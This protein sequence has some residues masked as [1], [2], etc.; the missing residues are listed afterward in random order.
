MPRLR[1]CSVPSKSI[2]GAA[3]VSQLL[4]SAAALFWY[5]DVKVPAFWRQFEW[6]FFKEQLSY[7]LPYGAFGMLWVIQKDLDNYFVSA[8][9]RTQQTMRFMRW[10]GWMCRYLLWPWNRSY[11]S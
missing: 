9:L 1:C 8:K 5:L 4:L 3:L 2:I 11:R 7:A 6:G 10:A